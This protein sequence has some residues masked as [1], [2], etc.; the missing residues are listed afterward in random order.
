MIPQFPQFKKLEY[1]DR[2]DVLSF[3]RDHPPYSDYNFTSLWIWD[4][5]ATINWSVL[6]GNLVI[7]FTDYI[8]K[9][10]FVSFLGSENLEDTISTLLEYSKKNGYG[11]WLRLVPESAIIGDMEEL[12]QKFVLHEDVDQH[13]YIVALSDLVSLEGS[14]LKEHR[15]LVRRFKEENEKHEIIFLNPNNS[16]D[17]KVLTECFFAWTKVRDKD[18]FDV[19]NETASLYRYFQFAENHPTEVIGIVIDGTLRAFSVYEPV[20]NK[21]VMSHY[22]KADTTY[23][24]IYQYLDHVTAKHLH[25]RGYEYFNLEQDLGIL[26][27]RKAKQGSGTSF[28]L[29][30]YAISSK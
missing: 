18:P 6:E 22:F 10:P 29:K 15:K 28:F 11:D 9:L 27:L 5:Q 14:R 24:G 8:T 12:S 3:L 17:R 25:E 2:D 13:D 26:T 23:K 20:H 7:V 16:N 19:Q 21:F 1:G 4:I 30:K